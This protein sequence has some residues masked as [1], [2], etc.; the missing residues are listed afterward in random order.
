MIPD[1]EGL[2][3]EIVNQL[4]EP[5]CR[6]LAA[7]TEKN[8]PAYARYIGGM[9]IFKLKNRGYRVISMRLVFLL[10]MLRLLPVL[11]FNKDN[12]NLLLL[13]RK[14]LYKVFNRDPLKPKVT[15]GLKT[16]LLVIAMI[17]TAQC[18]QKELDLYEY[19]QLH[20]PIRAEMARSRP[21]TRKGRKLKP[22]YNEIMRNFGFQK[23]QDK[24][25]RHGA[26]KWLLARVVCASVTAAAK[27]LNIS[28]EQLS[29]DIR[30]FDIAMGYSRK[31]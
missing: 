4:D 21:K 3:S 6:K 17:I 15:L 18:T 10:K 20:N 31:K 5:G 7:F 9:I 16:G 13:I 22:E 25:Y 27:R 14:Y 19:D 1:A 11:Y 26:K 23:K 2:F 30:G 29:K 8:A 24:Y 28:W 12:W